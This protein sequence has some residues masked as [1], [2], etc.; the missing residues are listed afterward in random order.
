MWYIITVKTPFF[1]SPAYCVP[2]MT[3]SPLSKDTET[4]VELLMPSVKRLQGKQPELRI[5][6][7]FCFSNSGSSSGVAGTS[8]FCMKSAWYAREVITRTGRR[9]SFSQPAHA[10]TT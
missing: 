9:Y 7:G 5:K 8:M 10:S 4:E 1:I 3:I 6:N 2:K